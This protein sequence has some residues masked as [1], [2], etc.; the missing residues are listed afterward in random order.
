[1]RRW[2]CSKK[3]MLS[4]ERSTAYSAIPRNS[5]DWRKGT[6]LNPVSRNPTAIVAG[7]ATLLMFDAAVL[8]LPEAWLEVV[9]ENALDVVLVL[10]KRLFGA[11]PSEDK[12]RIVVVD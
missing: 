11:R 10:E 3:Q 2:V 5:R 12:T 1:M 4:S 9:R 8:L 7:L 6:M